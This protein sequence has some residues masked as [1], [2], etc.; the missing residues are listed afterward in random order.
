MIFDLLR[1]TLLINC[2]DYFKINRHNF[3]P[4]PM[5]FNFGYLRINKTPDD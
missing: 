2:S 5:P 4:G 3:Q 1:R